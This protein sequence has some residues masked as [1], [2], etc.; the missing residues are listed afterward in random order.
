MPLPIR[1]LTGAFLAPLTLYDLLLRYH[2]KIMKR[3]AMGSCINI[4]HT[5]DKIGSI[6]STGLL[7]IRQLCRD[8]SRVFLFDEGARR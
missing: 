4:V 8:E 7:V 2:C 1:F 5:H 3:E 6:P